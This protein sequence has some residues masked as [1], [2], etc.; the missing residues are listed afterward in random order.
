M[1]IYLT[2]YTTLL[3]IVLTPGVLLRIPKNGSKLLVAGVHGL[4]FAVVYY[5]TYKLVWGLSVDGFKDL[6]KP[7]RSPKVKMIPASDMRESK[8]KK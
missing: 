7:S 8:V 4:A 2:L 1:N 3:F 6:K 5:F